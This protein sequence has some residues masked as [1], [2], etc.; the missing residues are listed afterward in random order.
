MPLRRSRFAGEINALHIDTVLARGGHGQDTGRLRRKFRE[1]GDDPVAPDDRL[2]APWAALAYD[3][4]PA[5]AAQAG[6]I[7]EHVQ[8]ATLPPQGVPSGPDYQQYWIQ[9]VQPWTGAAMAAAVA[10]S[11]RPCRL[12]NDLGFVASHGAACRPRRT[13]R[14]LD[15]PQ[16][17]TPVTASA[18]G[19]FCPIWT[20]TVGF[21]AIWISAIGVSAVART[22]GV[23]VPRIARTIRYGI[24][25]R[26]AHESATG[27][28]ATSQSPNRL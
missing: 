14:D 11:I 19:Q 21:A 4:S 12:A 2:V 16:S 7:L 17:A 1:V 27:S 13:D 9:R 18:N 25:R 3:G 26:P 8:I 6:Q 24:W 15:L 22:V 28:P 23:A 5:T 20:P 10:G